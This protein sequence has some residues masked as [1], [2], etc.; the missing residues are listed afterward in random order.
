MEEEEVTKEL[1]KIFF[2]I[3]FLNEIEHLKKLLYSIAVV[4]DFHFEKIVP[5]NK[6]LPEVLYTFRI[7]EAVSSI[8]R[9][10]PKSENIDMNQLTHI[11]PVGVIVRQA[12]EAYEMFYYLCI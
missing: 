11:A 2:E 6:N 9:L 1:K 5:Q 10:V 8:L 12:F 3:N 7:L 4:S